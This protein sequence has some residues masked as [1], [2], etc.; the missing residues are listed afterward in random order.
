MP[1][2]NTS[3]KPKGKFRLSP[4]WDI[5]IPFSI[6]AIPTG[7]FAFLGFLTKG[8]DRPGAQPAIWVMVMLIVVEV[9]GIIAMALVILTRYEIG[10]QQLSQRTNGN[11]AIWRKLTLICSIALVLLFD[12]LTNVAA[13]FAGAGPLLAFAAP[14][15][16]GYV[17]CLKIAF[18]GI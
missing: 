7:L 4:T 2:Q 10:F 15:F 11:P 18:A 14:A 13:A 17:I 8:L 12:I 9:L 1:S 5:C 6:A 16:I 3:T